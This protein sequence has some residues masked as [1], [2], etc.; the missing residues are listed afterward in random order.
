MLGWEFPSFMSGG[1]GVHCENLSKKIVEQ[2]LEV[3]FFMP[4]NDCRIRSGKV[5]INPVY[6]SRKHSRMNEKYLDPYHRLRM[7]MSFVKKTSDFLKQLRKHKLMKVDAYNVR[8]AKSI[9][10]KHFKEKFD[11]IHVHGRFNVGAAVMARKLT[12]VPFVWTVHSTIFDES[13]ERKP[14]KWQYNIEK[15]G[16]NEADHIIAVS[17]RT[18]RQLTKRFKAKS[19]KISVVY[20]GIDATKF[21]VTKKKKKK[22]SRVLFH[23]RLTNQKGPKYFLLA[24]H[25]YL[26][27]HRAQFYMSGKGHLRDN[28]E[29]FA[30]ELRIKSSVEFPG[31]ISQTRLPQWYANN[32]VFVLP[33]VSEPFG[34]TVLESMAAGTPVIISKTSGVGEIIKNC[35]K[36]DYWDATGIAK[37]MERVLTN[38]AGYQELSNAGIEEVKEWSWD[39]IARDTKKVYE[40]TVTG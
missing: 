11:L 33:S 39:R 36:V 5:K 14:D 28:L 20:N 32:D 19:S 7:E 40:E 3:E 29:A 22:R 23:G 12:G 6:Y 8:L 13:S 26:K 25:E 27:S 1:L 15:I 9:A 18:K 16:V 38:E 4:K 2:G 37:A 21:A 34:I 31:F 24:A 17:K 10:R 30:R 35:I